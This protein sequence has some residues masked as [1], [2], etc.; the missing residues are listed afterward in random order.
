VTLDLPAD[1]Q[2]RLREKISDEEIASV[3]ASMVRALAQL[4]VKR[5]QRTRG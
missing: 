4:Q 1:A 3:N 2:A 5:R